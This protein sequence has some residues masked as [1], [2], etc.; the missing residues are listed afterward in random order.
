MNK[1]LVIIKLNPKDPKEKVFCILEKLNMLAKNRC[2]NLIMS[3]A[4]SYL[5]F[6]VLIGKLKLTFVFW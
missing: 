3:V 1:N 5:L 4:C 6:E 2:I